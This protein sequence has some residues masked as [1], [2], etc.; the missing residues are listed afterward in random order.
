MNASPRHMPRHSRGF[1]LLEI[2]ITVAILAF[3]LLGL[4][5]LQAKLHM[6]EMEA[7]QRAQAVVLLQDFATRLQANG[8]NAASYLTGSMPL[9]TGNTVNCS[10]LPTGVAARDRCEWHLA[11]LGAAETQAG[12]NVGGVLNA[13][14]CVE[15]LQA[16]VTA[17]CTP[18]RYRITAAWQGLY[19]TAAPGLAC[20]S[21][22]YGNEALRRAASIIVTIGLPNCLPP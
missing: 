7:Y 9:G 16:P 14:G 12:T 2:L 21:G 22:Q 6:S 19:Q 8:D 1:T 13:R 15:Q 4:A 3:G 17:T 10:P 11:L 20:G 5:N 18:G